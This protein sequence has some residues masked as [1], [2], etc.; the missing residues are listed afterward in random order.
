MAE[1][2]TWPG[3]ECVRLLGAGSYGKV[4]EIKRT[5]FGKTYSAALKVITIPRDQADIQNAYS[6]GMSKESVT[7]YFRSIV[8]RITDEFAL[9]SDLKGFTNIV[10]YQDHKVIEH[11]NEIGWDILIRMELLTSLQSYCSQNTLSERQIVKLGCD[12]CRALELCWEMKIV[13]RDIKPENIFVNR[14]GD[15]EL[16]DFGVARTIE[17]EMTTASLAGTETYMAPEVYWGRK[18]G[19]T[20]DIYSLAIVLYRYLNNNRA[21]FLPLGDLLAGDRERAKE[22]RMSGDTIPEPMNGSRQLKQVVLKALNYDPKKRY[23]SA[24][25]FRRELELCIPDEDEDEETSWRNSDEDEDEET[26][27]LNPDEDEDEDTRLLESDE[28]EDT[29]R[30]EPEDDDDEDTKL[31]EPT[32]IGRAH[33]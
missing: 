20:A 30:L 33:V 14:H 9:M 29:K 17:N 5:E 28:D 10:S 12:I 7:T 23:Q 11:E 13:H 8:E 22:H 26:S 3:W 24:A 21:P 18:Y 31:L 25:E 19:P 4:Y 15:Y 1:I 6:D 27:R 16:G 2:N 32:E